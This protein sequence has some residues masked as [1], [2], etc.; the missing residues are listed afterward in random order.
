MR[1]ASKLFCLGEI[2]AI[3]NRAASQKALNSIGGA[4]IALLVMYTHN[5]LGLCAGQ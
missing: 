1:M 3:I 5:L 2:A 4:E